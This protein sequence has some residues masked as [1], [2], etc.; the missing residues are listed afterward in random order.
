MELFSFLGGF[1]VLALY[2][3]I[4]L[5]LVAVLA[6]LLARRPRYARITGAMP[7][8]WGVTAVSVALAAVLQFGGALTSG[9]TYASERAP[10][11]A[12]APPRAVD[13]ATLAALRSAGFQ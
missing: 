8:L 11:G 7:F 4:A 5:I 12:G 9:S 10:F 1:R 6:Q 2:L 13:A 3:P